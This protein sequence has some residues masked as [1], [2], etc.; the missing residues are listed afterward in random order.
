MSDSDSYEPDDSGSE[1]ESDS[2]SD[3]NDGALVIRSI[4]RKTRS[5]P[6][7][8]SVSVKDEEDLSNFDFAEYADDDMN[9]DARQD[10]VRSLQARL[11]SIPREALNA[12]NGLLVEMEK[13]VEL[14]SMNEHP[15][16]LTVEQRHAVVWTAT[17]KELFFNMLDRKGKN[18][19]KEIA[20]AIPEKSELEVMHYI[21]CLHEGLV[22]QH[23]DNEQNA[24][25]LMGDYPGAAEVSGECEEKLEELADIMCLKEEAESSWASRDRY[26]KYGIITEATA[27]GLVKDN[28]VCP[29]LHGGIDKALN[30]LNVPVWLQ[31]S[32]KL[33]MNLGGKRTE[34][35]WI[36]HQSFSAESPSMTGDALMDF[37]ALTM[38][39]TRRLIQSSLFFSMARISAMEQMGEEIDDEV[40]TVRTRDV[41]AAIETMNMKYDRGNILVDFA[42]RNGVLIKDI[43]N[44]KGWK[45]QVLDYDYVE[46]LL[47]LDDDEYNEYEGSGS[48]SPE[49]IV[50]HEDDDYNGEDEDGD[51]AEEPVDKPKAQAEEK[52]Q[53]PQDHTSEPESEPQSQPQSEPTTENIE[54]KAQPKSAPAPEATIETP[55][56]KP[57]LQ[58]VPGTVLPPNQPPKARPR[59]YSEG[60]YQSEEIE[61]EEGEAA[62]A[63]ARIAAA[64]EDQPSDAEEVH[65]ARIDREYDRR[66]ELHLWQTLQQPIPPLLSNPLIAEED[67]GVDSKHRPLIRRR[68]REEMAPWR[69]RTLYRAEW[70]EFGDSGSELETALQ[71][72]RQKRR[73]IEAE[74]AAGS[75][76]DVDSEDYGAFSDFEDGDP[77]DLDQPR[78][79]PMVAVELPKYGSPAWAAFLQK[80]TAQSQTQTQTQTQN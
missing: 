69:D 61:G 51:E 78:S 30:I 75:G 34:D 72:N 24:T 6:R 7:A 52:G 74:D 14:K 68:T 76:R 60:S 41:R 8:A 44:K 43:Q 16:L 32:R 57:Q 19:I 3:L 35:N 50:E 26:H 45:P 17:E 42:R 63:A 20:A 55:T 79:R 46:E 71:E 47:T 12:Y 66:S 48:S 13:E 56:E 5:S 53:K 11:Q 65:A 33:F 10:R 9:T 36:Y 58:S 64:A 39:I 62:A 15:E 21:D 70:E 59:R 40:E 80:L 38:S 18:G 4:E 49:S 25:L 2:D 22:K 27:K 67:M 1:W 54:Q 23:V 28:E 37:Y 29:P 77:M 31:L 73:K